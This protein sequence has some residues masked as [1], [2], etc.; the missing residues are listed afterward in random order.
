MAKF[1]LILNPQ[2][3]LK[4]LLTRYWLYLLVFH[5]PQYKTFPMLSKWP[6]KNNNKKQVFEERRTSL[7][8]GVPVSVLILIC[9]SRTDSQAGLAMCQSMFVNQRMMR[10]RSIVL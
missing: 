8:V 2:K 7:K 3:D 6:E 1:Q 5:R 9:T 4:S 10:S